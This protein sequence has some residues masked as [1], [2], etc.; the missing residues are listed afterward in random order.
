MGTT[1][2]I[3]EYLVIGFQV[4]VWVVLVLWRLL[5]VE[6]H[7]HV[8]GRLRSWP[9]LSAAAVIPLAYTLGLVFDRSVGLLTTILKSLKG[10][11]P[12]RIVELLTKSW[13][14]LRKR[15]DL[16]VDTEVNNGA[17]RT[18]KD[19]YI[20]LTYPEAYKL[21]QKGLH[22]TVLLRATFFNSLLIILVAAW[23]YSYWPF[24]A[25][26]VTVPALLAWIR[27]WL[28]RGPALDTLYRKA[29]ECQRRKEQA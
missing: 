13:K 7:E 9:P 1:Q 25:L 21:V 16:S 3:V 4:L 15:L 14:W 10:L 29:E 12:D 23:G 28:E 6:Q 2:I 22:H 18:E 5:P 27:C 20:M 19:F 24:W 26:P 17:T 11:L 8:L